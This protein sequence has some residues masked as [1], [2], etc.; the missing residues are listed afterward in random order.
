MKILH[1]IK[2][3]SFTVITNHKINFYSINIVVSLLK[4]QCGRWPTMTPD[5]IKAIAYES[6][7]SLFP[8][9]H[10]EATRDYVKRASCTWASIN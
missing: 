6:I 2:F 10:A 8:E 1:G 7:G 4:V 3:Y 5:L 9:G